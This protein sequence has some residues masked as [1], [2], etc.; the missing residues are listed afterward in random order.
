[1]NT[2][3]PNDL[4]EELVEGF[5]QMPRGST[6]PHCGTIGGVKFVLK[7]PGWGD[8][9]ANAEAHVANEAVAD[10]TSS[11]NYVLAVVRTRRRSAFNEQERIKIRQWLSARL[12]ADSLEVIIQ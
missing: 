3:F 12:Q 11:H 5:V 8:Y 10:S 2:D 7:C 9:S 6:H 1:M 4:N